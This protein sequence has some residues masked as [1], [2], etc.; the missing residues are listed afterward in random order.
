MADLSEAYKMLTPSVYDDYNKRIIQRISDEHRPPQPPSSKPVIEKKSMCST[1]CSSISAFFAN[2]FSC[3]NCCI[4]TATDDI[5]KT[6]HEQQPNNINIAE[7][8]STWVDTGLNKIPQDVAETRLAMLMKQREEQDREFNNITEEER[9]RQFNKF[10]DIRN[11]EVK[12]Q[13]EQM[14]REKGY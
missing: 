2:I 13:F 11:K 10:N 3:C 7:N 9:K 4:T 1:M 6:E 8:P 12:A 14:Q 5:D